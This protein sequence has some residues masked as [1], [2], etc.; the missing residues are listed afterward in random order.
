MGLNSILPY[1]VAARVVGVAEM[2]PAYW[3]PLGWLGWEIEVRGEGAVFPLLENSRD[4]LPAPRVTEHWNDSVRNPLLGYFGTC[5]PVVNGLQALA[6]ECRVEFSTGKRVP[7]RDSALE[8]QFWRS[9]E[10]N[11]RQDG[12]RVYRC[13]WLLYAWKYTFPNI[14]FLLYSRALKPGYRNRKILPGRGL[15]PRPPEHQLHDPT[16]L[17]NWLKCPDPSAGCQK[18]TYIQLNYGM[19]FKKAYH[20]GSPQVLASYM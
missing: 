1:G 15:N 14:R 12:G 9:S 19:H 16:L 5:Y 17:P 4:R 10:V 6:S 20:T 2:L 8:F 3:S 11:C 13:G 7:S 18:S